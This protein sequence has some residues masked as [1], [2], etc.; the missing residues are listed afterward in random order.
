MDILHKQQIIEEYKNGLSINKL[1]YKY[2]YSQRNIADMLIQEGIKIR[3]GI[4]RITFTAEQKEYIQLMAKDHCSIA[5][6]AKIFNIDTQ[7][8]TSYLTLNNI[9]IHYKG[10]NKNLKEDFFENIDS[11]EKAYLL[12][13]L[14]TDGSVRDYRGCKQIRLQLQA[15]DRV[16][17]ERIMRLLQVDSKLQYDS[18]PGKEAYGFEFASEKMFNDLAK[19]GIVPNKTKKTTSFPWVAQEYKIPLLRGLFDGDGIFSYKENYNEASVGFCAYSEQL[20]VSFQ[21]EIDTLIKKMN[22]NKIQ[23]TSAWQC[24]WRGRRQVLSILNILYQDSTIFLPRKY[25]KYKKLLATVADNDMV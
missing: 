18:R 4:P 22:H 2:P 24:K 8:L 25:E 15:R 21:A 20:V 12:G 13:I 10:V 1:R 7:T 11:E 19:Y 3:G 17:V 16:F 14:F 5:E 9:P 23:Y 6:I